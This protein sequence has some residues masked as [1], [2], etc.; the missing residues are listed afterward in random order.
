MTQ[1]PAII[2]MLRQLRVLTVS[3]NRLSELPEAIGELSRLQ[4]L[5]LY[6]NRLTTLPDAIGKL[7]ELRTLALRHNRLA[8]LPDSIGGLTQLRELFAHDNQLSALPEAIGDLTQLHSLYLYNNRLTALPATIG[9]LTNLEWLDVSANR[10]TALPQSI[11]NLRNLTALCLHG[12]DALGLPPEV[13][14]PTLHDVVNRSAKPADPAG[15]LDYYFRIRAARKPLNEAKL[16]L[17]GHGAVGKT[18]LVKRLIRDEFDPHEAQT[19]GIRIEDWPLTLRGDDV[20]L[21]VWDFG[22][23]E[24]M[25]AT[26]QFFLT[27]RSLYLLVLNGRGGHE[28]SDAEYWLNLIQSFGADSPVI[29]VLNKIKEHPFDL[30]RGGLKQKFPAIRDFIATDCADRTGIAELRAAIERE[31]DALEHLRASFPAAWFAIK[32]RLSGMKEN[33]LTFDKYRGICDANGESGREAQDALATHLHNLGIAL[34]YR[35]DPRLRG[36][37]VLNPR[38]VTQGIYAIL[39]DRKLAARRGELSL[40]YLGAILDPQAYPE[41]LHGF[42]LELMRK[43]ELCFPFP[44]EVGHY[45]IPDLLGK[46]EPV[47]LVSQFDP[48]ECLNFEYHYP[49]V[50]EGMLPRFIVR[51]YVL[52]TGRPRW[53]TGAVLEFEGCRALVKADVPEKRVRISIQGPREGRRNLLAIIRYEFERIHAGFTFRPIETVPVP[54][55]PDLTVPYQKLRVLESKGISSFSEVA[56][57]DVLDLSVSD[58]LN[59][60]DVPEAAVEPARLFYSYAHEDERLRDELEVQLKLFQRR[61]LILHWHDR[62]ITPGKEWHQQI[63]HYLNE[64]NIILLLVSPDFLASDYCCDVE[65]RRALERHQAGEARGVPIIVRDVDWQRTVLGKLQALP[66]DGK[67]VVQWPDRDTAW[68][69]VAAGIERVVR[70]LRGRERAL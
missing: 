16:I 65:V 35:D 58:L 25:H 34:N 31:T 68:K 62:C 23:Q 53:R 9:N 38:W 42:L 66:T 2:G 13:L 41:E 39:T 24:I 18:S 33:Y 12:N 46:E 5:Y 1:L 54:G 30:N 15:I 43:F 44:D 10:L 52:N 45:L 55:H 19:H 40:P 17:V 59:G 27:E 20:R 6:H 4:E 60:V 7:T 11:R 61:G 29:V 47:D 48:R 63:D 14:G 64:A 22:G 69:E 67:P 70:E 50:P 57:D 3:F 21:H 36:M 51:N 37:H 28:D 32:D 49:V 56:G 8:A 26:H